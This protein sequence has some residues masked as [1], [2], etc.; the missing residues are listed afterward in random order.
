[1]AAECLCTPEICGPFLSPPLLPGHLPQSHVTWHPLCLGCG[2]S[3]QQQPLSLQAKVTFEDVA[4]LLTRE[5]WD[6]LGPAQRG[7]YRHVMM[8]TYGNVVSLGMAP[9]YDL[10]VSVLGQGWWGGRSSGGSLGVT[11]WLLSSRGRSVLSVSCLQAVRVGWGH[12]QMLHRQRTSLPTS[13]TSRIQAGLDLPARARRR[14][15]GPGQARVSGEQRPRP[16][17][18]RW[19]SRA[20]SQFTEGQAGPPAVGADRKQQEW[21]SS[22]A[23]S[24]KGACIQ[25]CAEPG[26]CPGQAVSVPTLP[27]PR[28]RPYGTF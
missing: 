2:H 27:L 6:H 15:V 23:S 25:A 1:M 7:L 11:S 19:V 14:A 12:S 26:R 13:R 28:P 5:E 4:V 9:Q 16:W 18:L 22:R 8:E 20:G 17:P 21:A 24:G 3:V 10:S